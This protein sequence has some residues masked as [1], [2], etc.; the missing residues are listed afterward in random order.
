MS[1]NRREEILV[2][3][4][5]ILTGLEGIVTSVRNRGLLDNDACPAIT[6]LDGDEISKPLG[7]TRTLPRGRRRM[8]PGII[9]LKPQVFLLLKYKK[10]G[11]A[12]VGE[13][14]NLYRGKIIQAIAGDEQL[15][16]LITANGDITYDGCETD[17]KNGMDLTGTMQLSFSISHS[18]D[19]YA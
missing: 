13:A 2:Q 14:L 17:L 16:S 10:P 8:S 6:L 19:P 3:V 18:F 1:V 15:L 5:A 11:N 9:T 12:G 7:G 4:H